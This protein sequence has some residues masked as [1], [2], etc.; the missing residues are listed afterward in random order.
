MANG[1]RSIN[2]ALAARACCRGAKSAALSGTRSVSY[3]R[4][5]ALT[6]TVSVD[7]DDVASVAVLCE[8]NRLVLDGDL[9]ID[10]VRSDS[11]AFG[12]SSLVYLP[13][14]GL[15]MT[16]YVHAMSNAEMDV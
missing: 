5:S 2:L 13:I 16:L 10:G 6:S 15:W 8:P 12:S 11:R 14:E 7:D 9:R 3:L 4:G 1:V